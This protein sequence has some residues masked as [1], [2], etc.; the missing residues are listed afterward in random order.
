MRAYSAF[1]GFGNSETWKAEIM[2]LF[3]FREVTV[4]KLVEVL[5]ISASD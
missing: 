4:M 2:N 1:G 3:P 5:T